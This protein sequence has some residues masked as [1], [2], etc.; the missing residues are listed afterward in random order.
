L[1]K[2]HS[3]LEVNAEGV[4]QV[5]ILENK[6]GRIVAIDQQNNSVTAKEISKPPSEY[7]T[8]EQ[9]KTDHPEVLFYKTPR[10]PGSE[11]FYFKSYLRDRQRILGFDKY[12][13]ALDPTQV[14]PH[15]EEC[16]FSMV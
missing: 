7:R 14:H 13:N 15:Q 1:F 16:L 6:F 3:V 5:V 9:V 2:T 8:L 10:E 4:H 12:G 11:W